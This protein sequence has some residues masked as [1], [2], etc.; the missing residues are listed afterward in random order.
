[1]H[2]KLRIYEYS[3]LVDKIA[4]RFRS[5]AVRSLSFT[6]R[7]QLNSSVIL[8]TVNFWISI[9]MFLHGCIKKIE[10]LCSRFLWSGDINNFRIPKVALST[11]CLPKNE[12]GL[13][14]RRFKIWNTTLCLRLIWLLSLW[15]A[16]HHHHHL[17]HTDF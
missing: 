10:S 4:G 11:I 9:F 7:L 16:W 17:Q 2:R 1:M 6:G 15:V 13:G 8:G 3:P 14:L 5:W 12:G